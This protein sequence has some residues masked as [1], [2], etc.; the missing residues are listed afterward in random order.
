MDQTSPPNYLELAADL[1]SAYVSHN[2]LPAADLPS[3]ISAVHTALH[4]AIS[5]APH[6]RHL[7]PSGPA[8]R[9]EAYAFNR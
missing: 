9:T 1:A 6:L 2:A 7:S 8:A 3:L 4:Q 5:V